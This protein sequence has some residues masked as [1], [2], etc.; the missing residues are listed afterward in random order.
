VTE[1]AQ[2]SC[3]APLSCYL[4]RHSGRRTR[5]WFSMLTVTFWKQ[6]SRNN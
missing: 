5:S 3:E 1:G 4:E 2:L 6:R